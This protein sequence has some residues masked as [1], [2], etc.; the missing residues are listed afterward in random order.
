MLSLG[1]FYP[2]H[3]RFF[4]VIKNMAEPIYKMQKI[5]FYCL[6]AEIVSLDC[7]FLFLFFS[8]QRFLLINAILN[9]NFFCRLTIFSTQNSKFL[10][11]KFCGQNLTN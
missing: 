1:I 9:F 5:L 10:I 6:S 3:F 7:C 11:V 8:N 4:K 2:R